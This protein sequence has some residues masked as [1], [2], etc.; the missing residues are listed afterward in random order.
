MLDVIL[1]LVV[2]VVIFMAVYL[3]FNWIAFFLTMV[4]TLSVIFINKHVLDKLTKAHD[5]CYYSIFILFTLLFG[6]DNVKKSKEKIFLLLTAIFVT[7]INFYL[8]LKILSL[9]TIFLNLYI[10]ITLMLMYLKT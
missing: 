3:C 6:I 5:V 8:E 2:A 10:V 9:F 1:T 4:T 7:L